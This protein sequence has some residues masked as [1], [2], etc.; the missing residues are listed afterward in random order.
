MRDGGRRRLTLALAVVAA[1]VALALAGAAAAGA[2]RGGA[3]GS[4]GG[5]AS[6]DHRASAG[7]VPPGFFGVVPQYPVGAG[8]LRLM[9]GVVG[10]LRIPVNW[11]EV[12]PSPGVYDWS[13]LDAE[14]GAAAAAGI[15]VLPFVY[16]TPRWLAKQ[17]ALPPL[18][19]QARSEWAGFLRTLVGRYG[20]R[21]DFW[22]TAPARLPIRTWQV[23][24]EPNFIL[25]WR[26]HPRPAAYA[27]LLGASARALRGADPGARIVTGGVAPVGAGYLPWTFLRKLYAVKGV[28]R[29]FD[30]VAIHP[31]AVSLSNTRAQVE[32][33]RQIMDRAGDGRKP[34]LISEL[35]VASHGDLPSGFVQGESGQASYLGAAFR[36]L[37]ANRRAWHLAGVDWFTWRDQPGADPHC[38]FCQGAGLL[39]VDGTPKLAWSAYRAV[40]RLTRAGRG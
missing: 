35:G 30:E 40:V 20:P 16:G 7:K 1:A 24:N 18:A 14:I 33:T 36:L 26:P 22:A 8:D 3:G 10:T 13:G 27:K 11:F 34:L 37:V 6:G 2:A 15:R 12:E 39:A 32:L 5:D 21:G 9:R 23:W 17:P 4:V 19:G 38:S 25:F 31:Y 28:K 29:S